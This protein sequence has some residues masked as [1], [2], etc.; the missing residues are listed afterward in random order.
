VIDNLGMGIAIVAEVDSLA[1][2][3]VEIGLLQPLKNEVPHDFF[4][5]PQL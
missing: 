2:S 3:N 4:S 5:M 1:K